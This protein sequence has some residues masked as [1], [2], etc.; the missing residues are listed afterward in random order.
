MYVREVIDKFG[1]GPFT[2]FLN[3]LDENEEKEEEEY[4]TKA[5]SKLN[6]DLVLIP[7]KLEKIK[8]FK[9][10]KDLNYEYENNN[11]KID[12]KNHSECFLVFANIIC[13]LFFPLFQLIGVQEQLIVLNSLLNEL[14]E[15]FRLAIKDTPRQYNFY[16]VIKICS[17]KEIPNMEISILTSFIGIAAIKNLGYF[18]TNFCFQLLPGLMFFFFFYYFSFHTGKELEENYIS[19]E[20]I[21]LAVTT[22]LG[23]ILVGGSSIISLKQISILFKSWSEDDNDDRDDTTSSSGGSDESILSEKWE[24]LNDFLTIFFYIFF[25]GLSLF[26]TILINKYLIYI[27]DNDIIRKKFLYGIGLIYT[28]TCILTLILFAIHSCT[29]K[30]SEEINESEGNDQIQN[31]TSEE[32]G[33]L[34]NGPNKNI[35]NKLTKVGEKEKG[36]KSIK[37]FT[38]LGYL[39]FQKETKNK[40]ICIIS[41]YE[42]KCSWII[43]NM[44][45]ILN[46]II[47]V[48]IL[49]C[50]LQSISFK[51]ILSDRML[52]N[53][54]DWKNILFLGILI[55]FAFI[56]GGFIA[57]IFSGIQKSFKKY[58][59]FGIAI[60][61]V[62]L[63]L[64]LAFLSIITLIF[65]SI[66]YA[67]DN[68]GTGWDYIYMIQIIFFKFVECQIFN[69]FGVFNGEIA[70]DSSLIL[71][72]ENLIW[73][74]FENISDVFEF[75]TRHLVL[76]Q[77][78]VSSITTFLCF[79]FPCL[80]CAIKFNKSKQ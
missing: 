35:S 10:Y 40:R 59:Y 49:L 24:V 70:L 5:K 60:I 76:V 79:I 51:Q 37:T 74:I 15:E 27:L 19:S 1:D 72:F 34:S 6:E 28:I 50:Q 58:K 55:L 22:I 52:N 48:Y 73:M 69:S 36:I 64:F 32:L 25:S 66:H 68:H 41:K 57:V 71:N 62:M 9:K 20:I 42:G 18:W 29:F 14:I 65:S 56:F 75:S 46:I 23:F 26:F 61:F 54:S 63:Y 45:G 31:A 47:A 4:F 53:F 2:D 13:G 67:I 30:K 80:F 77:I 43:K 8:T 16:E 17:F 3:K 7:N 12:E 39:F 44:F 21:I 78:I 38:C 33:I 11:K